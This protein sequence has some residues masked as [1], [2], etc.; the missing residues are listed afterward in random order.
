VPAGRRGGAELERLGSALRL[1]RPIRR[2]R[3]VECLDAAPVRPPVAM[4]VPPAVEAS[5]G[6]LRV[7]VAD[8]YYANQ[9]LVTRLLE[10]RGYA[11]EVVADGQAAVDATLD[12][13]FDLVLM[14]CQMPLLDGYEA[15]AR[16]RSLE[17]GR[18]TPILAMTANDSLESRDACLR[19]GMD[20][21][22]TK[23][24]RVERLVE[25]LGQVPARDAK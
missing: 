8:D 7:L 14:D 18:R 6:A 25:A 12:R 10:K 4:P 19:A 11:V 23:P 13:A 15:T 3:L 24:I 21:Y 20:D 16:I 17:R 9:R 1:T 2:A 22:L 5:P